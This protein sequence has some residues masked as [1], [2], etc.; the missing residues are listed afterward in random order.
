MGWKVGLLPPHRNYPV[1]IA[2]RT[3]NVSAVLPLQYL[4]C[5][6]IIMTIF[7]RIVLVQ[8]TCKLI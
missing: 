4:Q 3:V 2:E 8:F 1:S 7:A 6:I 5:T